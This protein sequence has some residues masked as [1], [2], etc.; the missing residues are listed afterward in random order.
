MR[1]KFDSKRARQ[2]DLQG[3]SNGRESEGGEVVAADP[4]ARAEAYHGTL[5]GLVG[6]AGA[7]EPL[8]PIVQPKV[9]RENAVDGAERD[10]LA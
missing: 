8:K 4:G 1:R 9:A 5:G 2:V 10:Y 7:V 6:R 3:E